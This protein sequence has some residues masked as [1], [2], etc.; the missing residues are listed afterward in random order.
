C[1]LQFNGHT[2]KLHSFPTRRSS[3]LDDNDFKLE[4]DEED[5]SIYFF[6]PIFSKP[7]KQFFRYKTE[8]GEWKYFSDN[9]SLNLQLAGGLHLVRSE[10]HT[11]EFQSREN[12]VCRL[13]LEK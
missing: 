13:L 3:D 10:E 7:N 6:S 1:L 4:A 11:S 8:N 2:Q 5:I 9:L 12:L